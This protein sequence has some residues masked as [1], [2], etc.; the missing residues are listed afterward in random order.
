MLDRSRFAHV[1]AALLLVVA[2]G[3][4]PS[5][6]LA[7]SSPDDD[8]SGDGDSVTE[9]V[10]LNPTAS[11]EGTGT[12]SDTDA[13]TE[14]ATT[15]DP[16]AVDSDSSVTDDPS[17][18]DSASTSSSE[19]G[20][21]ASSGESTSGDDGDTIYDV[22]DGTLAEGT[23]VAI[24]GVVITGVVSNG[25]FAQ[26]PGGGQYGGVFVFSI[27]GPDISGAAVGDVVNFSG[28]TGEYMGNTEVDISAGTYEVVEAGDPLAAEVID[29]ADL[30]DDLTAEPWEGVL[31][32]IEGDLEVTSVSGSNEFV[33][34]DGTNDVRIDDFLYELPTSGDFAG[35]GVGATFT[36]I[37]GPLNYFNSQFK[38]AARD[39]GDFE[40]YAAP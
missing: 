28:V 6:P 5:E 35:F 13:T 25:V 21:E 27:G 9:G 19:A 1:P 18:T 2:C 30:G 34:N 20:S 4:A 10:T 12:G 40:G 31:V 26:E 16:S 32:R 39:A 7:T 29:A 22:Q 36:A 3:G 8:G 17:I 38:I 11:A 15:D 37:D 24:D 14:P 33:V 23:P